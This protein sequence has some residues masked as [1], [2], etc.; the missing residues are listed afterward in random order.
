MYINEKTN[1]EK[2]KKNLKMWK[3]YVEDILN[4]IMLLKGHIANEAQK[5][6]R[7]IW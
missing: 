1:L 3:K 7:K 2:L 6:L 4:M 5:Y